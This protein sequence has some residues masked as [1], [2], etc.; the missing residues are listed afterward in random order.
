MKHKQKL[1]IDQYMKDFDDGF[2]DRSFVEGYVM[3]FDK[4]KDMALELESTY[5]QE[6]DRLMEEMMSLGEEEV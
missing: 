2:P 4:A 5:L 1:A 6:G 3:G